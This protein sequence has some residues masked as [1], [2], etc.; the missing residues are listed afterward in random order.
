MSEGASPK[1]GGV[2]K[3][4]RDQRKADDPATTKKKKHRRLPSVRF[5][6]DWKFHNYKA[7][8]GN[9]PGTET[10]DESDGI[11]PVAPIEIEKPRK[12]RRRLPFG[13]SKAIEKPGVHSAAQCFLPE[14]SNATPKSN[15]V[16]FE[17][18]IDFTG[19]SKDGNE[20][21]VESVR[22][23]EEEKEAFLVLLKDA[24]PKDV[25]SDVTTN[26]QEPAG[27]FSQETFPDVNS[28]V[29][30]IP[31]PEEYSDLVAEKTS[32]IMGLAFNSLNRARVAAFS[33]FSHFEICLSVRDF[34]PAKLIRLWS[35]IVSKASDAFRQLLLYFVSSLIKRYPQCF[36]IQV[37]KRKRLSKPE[38]ESKVHT[39]HTESISN[40]D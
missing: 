36:N 25:I 33:S 32:P 35:F 14:G 28:L 2:L 22:S 18:A 23:V 20:L 27:M 13:K 31:N 40:E 19:C 3:K 4:K 24:V 16:T 29:V 12:T 30:T 10:A 38:E 11:P 15:K 34:S 21:I 6:K 9:R 1:F 37:K 5:P 7:D 8:D 26:I 39:T 17:T